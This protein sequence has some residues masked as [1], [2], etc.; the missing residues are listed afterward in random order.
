MEAEFEIR[1]GGEGVRDEHI[2]LIEPGNLQL[3]AG[4]LYLGR[5][6][7]EGDPHGG[8]AAPTGAEDGEDIGRPKGGDFAG[9]GEVPSED[10]CG[11]AG[12]ADGTG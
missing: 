9:A 2:D 5:L 12:S 7:G 8:G 4:E 11:S 6:T 3:R 1:A 10:A